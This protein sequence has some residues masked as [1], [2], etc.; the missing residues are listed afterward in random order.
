MRFFLLRLAATCFLLALAACAGQAAPTPRGPDGPLSVAVPAGNLAAALE[1]A[2]AE[3]AQT[4]GEPVEVI[5][6]DGSQYD[7]QVS[8]A[9]LAGLDRYDLVY[10]PQNALGKWV[11]YQ[12]LRPF[13]GIDPH[14]LEAWLPAL[15]VGQTLYGL[16]VQPDVVVIWYRA[17]LLANAGMAP[18]RTWAEFR[19]TAERLG[20]AAAGS[21]VD[22]AFDFAAL[23][24]SF[25]GQALE[26]GAGGYSVALESDPAVEA[27]TFYAD[28]V[29]AGRRTEAGEMLT[30][31]DVL[32][33]LR[34]G[35]AALG[36]APL[37]AAG[38]LRDCQAAPLACRDG[39]P[40]LAWAWLPNLDPAAASGSL[41][42]WAMPLNAARPQA[43]QRF[44][45]WL[46]GAEGGRAWARNGG[47]PAHRDALAGEDA[48][49]EWLALSRVERLILPLPALSTSAEA[50]RAYHSAVHAA[51][52][53]A[54]APADA[55][56]VGARQMRR[57][58]RMGGY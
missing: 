11:G 6:L 1:G 8:V 35:R 28:P 53:G 46:S 55:L 7:N 42:A 26:E 4:G 16:P 25:G 40:Q 43:A 10:L 48:P 36:I 44:A 52:S 14:G 49:P 15:T 41:G 57:A 54:Q 31:A 29:L 33:A 13:E 39:A 30:R 20:A 32:S 47:T 38:V 27:L 17:D 50:W 9:L 5:A 34:E 58:L 3:Y 18:P 2:A 12:T 37:S 24:A 23:L 21:D 56:A 19:Q 51:A 45:A 22:A